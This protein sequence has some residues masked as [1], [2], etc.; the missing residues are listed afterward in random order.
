[1]SEFSPSSI[2]AASCEQDTAL[3]EAIN[4]QLLHDDDTGAWQIGMSVHAGRNL[5]ATRWLRSGEL[6]FREH[7]IVA[8]RAVA[9][10]EEQLMSCACAILDASDDL[11]AAA[12]SLQHLPSS[13]SAANSFESW[14]QRMYRQTYM[15]AAGV[16]AGG[17]SP[18][19]ED[20]TWALGVASLNMHSSSH[21]CRGII[22][23]LS[24]L[25]EHGCE[26]SAIVEIGKATEG[27]VLS[28]RALRDI[29]PGH[30]ITICYVGYQLPTDERRRRL[31][32]QH[33]FRCTCQRCGP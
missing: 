8:A 10:G 16:G 30:P 15:D 7:P 23:V 26:P 25:M 18:S 12:R 24:S 20:V 9:I 5:I 28:L 29:A 2:F 1:M 33:G 22:G 3:E 4:A 32:F 11:R 21:P 17:S 14:A 27:S 19:L 31:Q 6:I 13:P